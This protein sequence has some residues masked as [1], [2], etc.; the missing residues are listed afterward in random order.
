M[1]LKVLEEV[2]MSS[3]IQV[4]DYTDFVRFCVLKAG[5]RVFCCGV[6]T[7]SLERRDCRVVLHITSWAKEKSTPAKWM[8]INDLVQT[9]LHVQ[10]YTEYTRNMLQYNVNI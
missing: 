3:G 6:L 10:I 1:K 5:T 2:S 7:W 4:V 9:Y 8:E